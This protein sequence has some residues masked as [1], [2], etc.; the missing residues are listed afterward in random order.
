[1]YIFVICYCGSRPAPPPGRATI[2]INCEFREAEQRFL[3]LFLKEENPIRSVVF[4]GH[5]P[6]PPGSA[7]P[8][9]FWMLVYIRYLILW[10]TCCMQPPPPE[11]ATISTKCEFCEA[12]QRFLLLFLEKEESY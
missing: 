11:R 4:W 8:K 1:M 9:F 3:L 5:A 6:K 12:E 10:Q 2:L 7:S